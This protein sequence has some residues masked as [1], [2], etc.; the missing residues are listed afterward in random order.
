[1]LSETLVEAMIRMSDLIYVF[2]YYCSAVAKARW[3]GSS[4]WWREP[5]LLRAAAGETAEKGE[6]SSDKLRNVGSIYFLGSG[7]LIH[8]V[9]ERAGQVWAVLTADDKYRLG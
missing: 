7:A 9:G 6:T 5:D 4:R 8:E 2:N 3:L 1:M